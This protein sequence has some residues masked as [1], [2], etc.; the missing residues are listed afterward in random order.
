MLRWRLILGAVFIGGLA[1]LF[2]LDWR[3]DRP[4]LYLLPLALV[5]AMV[6]TSELLTIFRKGGHEPLGLAVYIGVLLA[7]VA[8]AV[9]KLW[10]DVADGSRIFGV[11]WIAIGLAIGLLLVIASELSRYESGGRA[12][13]N[14]AVS[15]FAIAYVGGSFGFLIQLRLLGGGRL[16]MFA[17]LSMITIVKSSDIGQ[18][19]V[20]RLI[21]K[22]KLAPAVSPGKTW[23]G[24]FGGVLFALLAAWLLATY[25]APAMFG[26]G[27]A[28]SFGIRSVALYAIALMA[29]GLVGDLAE[30]LLKRD[31]GVK[32]SSNWMPGF[33]G[34]L[35]LL[36]SL[37]VAAP[38]AYLFWAM[39]W[40]A[41]MGC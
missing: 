32:D 27:A 21:G 23:E 25:A 20:G 26:E 30:S 34:V 3:A 29:S 39:G 38:V 8:S 17:L 22:H 2:R 10:P 41:N 24:A 16:G 18:Y 35:D 37:L 6:A 36:D 9:P 7:L 1:A 40:M 31:A 33:G 5:A 15:S 28:E 19:V 11:G 13:V 12:T 14:L 4:G